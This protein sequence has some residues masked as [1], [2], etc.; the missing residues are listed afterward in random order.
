MS[1]TSHPDHEFDMLVSVAKE[2]QRENERLKKLLQEYEAREV[3]LKEQSE[4]NHH[5]AC[6][7]RDNVVA[8]SARIVELE[9][10]VQTLEE[11]AF[12]AHERIEALR[13]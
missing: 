5:L 11:E 7:E 12:Q 13:G 1:F 2:C 9:E 4:A 6:L 10:E 3:L 8:A